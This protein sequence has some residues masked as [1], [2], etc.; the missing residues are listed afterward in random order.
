MSSSNSTVFAFVPL[1]GP[2]TVPIMLQAHTMAWLTPDVTA[3]FSQ[4]GLA[5]SSYPLLCGMSL[6]SA[7]LLALAL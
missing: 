7:G 3:D 1:L 4:L 5:G 6:A 2:R